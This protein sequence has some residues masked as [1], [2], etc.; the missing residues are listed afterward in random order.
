VARAALH[1]VERLD[2]VAAGR[3]GTTLLK[4]MP[5]QVKRSVSRSE[6]SVPL[7]RSSHH[8]RAPAISAVRK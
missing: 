3:P 8:Q 2:H 4:K 6:T 5:I 7:T 1:D